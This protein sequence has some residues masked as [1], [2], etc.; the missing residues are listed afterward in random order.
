[1]YHLIRNVASSF[2]ISITVAVVLHTGQINFGNLSSLVS[3]WNIGLAL[4]FKNQFI[5]NFDQVTIKNLTSE[6]NRQSLMIGYINSFKLFAI[7]SFMTIPFLFLIRGQ[8]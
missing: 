4:N 8:K 1:M 5:E 2:F 6:V 7:V 3:D